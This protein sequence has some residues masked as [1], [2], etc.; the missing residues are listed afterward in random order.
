[1]AKQNKRS[2]QE[3]D[4]YD[5]GYGKPPKAHQFKPGQSGNPK[6]RPR[7]RRNMRTIFTDVLH[8]KVAITENGKTRKMEKIEAIAQ[9]AVN[10]A[11]KG[12]PKGI[13]SIL[14]FARSAGLLDE[15]TD[16]LANQA[17]SANDQ[18]I[19]DAYLAR[20]GVDPKTLRDLDQEQGSPDGSVDDAER[21]D[22]K[23]KPGGQS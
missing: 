16:N 1:M 5:V 15:E 8:E 9:V 6:G 7:G 4:D 20:H 14:Q 21:V 23:E 2:T 10:K 19:L 18:A 13:A 3:D 12:D 22:K 11:L 17:S